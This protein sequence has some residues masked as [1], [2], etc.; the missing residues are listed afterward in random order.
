MENL[1]STP[2]SRRLSGSAF[3]SQYCR[4]PST[5]SSEF[6][7]SVSGEPSLVSC[8]AGLA[9][10]PARCRFFGGSYD[11]LEDDT[12]KCGCAQKHTGLAAVFGAVFFLD[13]GTSAGSAFSS[14]LRFGGWLLVTGVA[15]TDAF[16]RV[17]RRG[18]SSTV[19]LA[20][21]LLGIL[22]ECPK[23]TSGMRWRWFG[24][25]NPDCGDET[26]Q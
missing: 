11:W 15:V 7:A 18:G 22:Y 6:L 1:T 9:S 21:F 10:L 8:L 20:D 23:F 25:G 24:P 16:W 26:R 19:S 4:P 5:V 13:G 3:R 17:D 14:V 2:F 12:L